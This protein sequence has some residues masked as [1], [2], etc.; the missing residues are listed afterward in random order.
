MPSLF[1]SD[2]FVRLNALHTVT[3]DGSTLI[4]GPHAGTY[5][6]FSECENLPRMEVMA[7]M[8]PAACTVKL[9]PASHGIELFSRSMNVL[10]RAGF[11][12]QHAD[13]NYDTTNLSFPFVDRLASGARKKLAKCERAGFHSRTLESREWRTAH[14]LIWTNRHRAG[15][16]LSLGLDKIEELEDAL[17][18][19]YKFFGTFDGNKMIAAA[20]CVMVEADILYV[21]AWA[22]AEKNEFAPTVHICECIYEEAAFTQCRLLDVGTS[23]VEGVPNAGLIH[24]KESLG[25]RPSIKATMRRA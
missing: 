12:L 14:K 9:A 7:S 19:T 23:T 20:I 13:L 6:G 18:G 10:H 15:R 1:H 4:A 3:L 25:F 2:P 11:M 16:E 8:L 21:Y 17:P 5:G 22:D 24:F